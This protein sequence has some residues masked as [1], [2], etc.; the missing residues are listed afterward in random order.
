MDVVSIASFILTG[1]DL[2]H[3]YRKGTLNKKEGEELYCR[4]FSSLLF[5]I[6][7]NLKRCNTIVNLSEKGGVSA[8]ILSFFVRDSLFS[9]FCIM[10]PEPR[11]LTELNEIYSAFERIHHWQRITNDLKSDGAGYIVGYAK[12]LFNEKK[13][14]RKYNGL[15]E[16]LSS[17]PKQIHKPPKF[18]YSNAKE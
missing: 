18:F 5:E 4:I 16:V 9:D 8:G 15:L 11:T 2:T 17:L 6:H 12:D 10:C 13:L 7:Q 3:K 14:H 1:L